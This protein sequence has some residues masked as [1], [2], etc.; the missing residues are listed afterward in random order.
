MGA[1]D[2]NCHVALLDD[3]KTFKALAMDI[4]RETFFF[5]CVIVW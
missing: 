2:R 4:P 3:L 1:D 5:G